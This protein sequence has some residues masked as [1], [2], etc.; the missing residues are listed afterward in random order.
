VVNSGGVQTQLTGLSGIYAGSQAW[1]LTSTGKVLLSTLVDSGIN[2]YNISRQFTFSAYDSASGDLLALP[3]LPQ[4]FGVSQSASR[5]LLAAT[6]DSGD[7]VA[8][9]LTG[10]HQSSQA[11]IWHYNSYKGW[12]NLTQDYGVPS[13]S[14]LDKI[15]ITNEGIIYGVYQ[16]GFSQTGLPWKG[17]TM[18]APVPEP[19]SMILLAIGAGGFIAARR[20]KP[21]RA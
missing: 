2:P 1:D 5:S 18:Q 4:S 19:S 11:E 6:N 20:R 9:I 14:F 3:S 17:F 21:S 16:G 8:A 15:E 10:S 12:S 13:I 7:I